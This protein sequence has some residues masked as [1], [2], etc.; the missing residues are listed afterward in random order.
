MFANDAGAPTIWPEIDK[1]E[2]P[3]YRSTTALRAYKLPFW[4]SQENRTNYRATAG[5]PVALCPHPRISGNPVISKFRQ[6]SGIFATSEPPP[7]EGIA[8]MGI[9]AVGGSDL[10][11]GDWQLTGF[12][13]GG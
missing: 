3:L 8:S 2:T 1:D 12:K 11:G 5:P 4:P 9:S 6:I 10:E 13:S 7:P